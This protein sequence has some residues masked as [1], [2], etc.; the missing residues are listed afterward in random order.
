MQTLFSSLGHTRAALLPEDWKDFCHDTCLR[1]PIRELVHQDVFTRRS[2]DKP[3]RYA[4]DAVLLDLL[5]QGVRPAHHRPSELGQGVYHY[6][7]QQA[8]TRSV[9]G[10]RDLLARWIDATAERVAHAHVFSVACG[11]L[12]EAQ[13][14]R[15][16][17]ER[18]LGRFLALDQDQESLAVVERELGPLGVEAVPGSVKALLKGELRF[19]GMDFVY[20][21]GLY[22]YLPQAVAT[23]FTH[24]LFSML[25]PGGR[26]LLAN[27]A[28]PPADSSFK[29]YMEAFM[30]WWLLYRDE[31][32]VEAWSRDIPR[33]QLAGQR[34]FRDDTGNLIYLELVRR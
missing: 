29:A 21:S 2:F 23:P 24:L 6:L 20:A 3:R 18:R 8:S 16:V 30:D 14:S 32:E 5:Y 27:Y 4:G 12:R 26:L 17:Q 7:S 28:D 9:R 34:L 33:A 13:L 11:H 1:H 31:S 10:R 15:A 19:D 25:R 22:D